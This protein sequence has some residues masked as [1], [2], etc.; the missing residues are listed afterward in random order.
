[1]ILINRL[2]SNGDWPR[3]PV[4]IYM[5]RAALVR[6]RVFKLFVAYIVIGCVYIV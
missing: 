4:C 3:L 1:M 6:G 2:L 5:V